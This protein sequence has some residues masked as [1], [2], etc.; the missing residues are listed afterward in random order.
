VRWSDACNRSPRIVR[1]GLVGCAGFVVDTAVLYLAL[2]ELGMSYY[3]GRIVSYTLAASSTWYMN[4]RFTF[5]D[6][7]NDN[8]LGEWARFLMLNLFGGAVNY[9]V[10]AA[11]MRMHT[12]A[13]TAPAIGVAL[14]SVAGMFV[15]FYLSRRLVFNGRAG[16]DFNAP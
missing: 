7:R 8:R 9:G 2:Y 15:N 1:F 12:D 3:G 5:A 10:Y 4:R 11:Y 13:M 6:S 14:G 16:A